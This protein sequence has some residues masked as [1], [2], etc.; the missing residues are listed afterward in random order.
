MNEISDKRE[1]FG[2]GPY[3]VEARHQRLGQLLEG[4]K[5]FFDKDGPSEKGRGLFLGL[6]KDFIEKERG[7][8]LARHRS[9]ASGREIVAEHTEL[10][11]V[12]VRHLY[13]LA[14]E[15]GALG[16]DLGGFAL[17]A[18]GGYGRG[19]L[20][21][22]S[23]VDL[24]FLH[25]RWPEGRLG[26]LLRGILYPLWDVG[27]SVGHCCRC[28]ED[29]LQ[30]AEKD[31]ISRT[32]M[33]EAR[34]LVG[35]LALYQRFRRKLER[36]VRGR[37]AE[38]YVENKIAEREARY[39]KYGASL[40]LQEPNVKE[41]AG[42]LRDLHTAFWIARARHGVATF[43]DMVEKG[44]LLP[45]E[46]EDGERCLEFL[47]RLRNELHYLMGDKN[48]VLSL[49]LQRQVAENLGFHDMERAYG[50]ELFMQQYYLNARAVHR[51]SRT[52]VDRCAAKRSRMEAVMKK[53]RARDLGDGLTE[54]N[55]QI[56]IL[57]KDAGL[58]QEDPVRLMKIFWYA[59]QTGYGLS[60]EAQALARTHL[61]LIDDGFRSSNR[62]FGFFLAILREPV[63]VAHTLRT[64]HELGVLGAYIPEFA[65]LNCLVQF[66]FY[67]KYTVDEHTFIGLENLEK[68]LQVP[69]KPA[70]EFSVIAHELKRP[71]IL[72]LAVL[73]HDIGKGEGKEHVEK[74]V[75]MVPT[76]LGRWGLSEAEVE[77]VR[78][79]VAHHLTMAHIAERRDLDDERMVI[80]FV[81]K[82]QRVDLLKML[83]L[84]TYLDIKAVGPEAW[85]EWKGAL[86]WE[87][88]LKSHTIL[89]RGVPEGEEEL[90]KAAKIRSQ[91]L[92]ELSPEFSGGEVM[93]HL[94]MM[95]IRYQLT[96]SGAKVASHLRLARL[97]QGGEPLALV[98]T[99]F[100]LVG[101]SEVTVCAPGVP[102]RFAK[103]AGTFTANS[104][105][106][107]SA[108]IFTRRDGL[109]FRTFQVNDGRGS[110]ILDEGV[111]LRLSRDLGA[112]LEGRVEVEEL[113]KAR[114]P[115]LPSRE[116][117]WVPPRPSRVEFDNYVSETHTV[118]DVRT[119][120]R[121]GLLYS[122]S[123]A[124]STLGLDLSLAKITTEVDQAVDVFYVTERDGS[125][126]QEGER[127]EEIRTA[128]ERAVAQGL[129]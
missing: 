92:K 74:S 127:M 40:Y 53:L 6:F 108:Q 45:E 4:M 29:C 17:L 121:L 84:L 36:K 110:A 30:I 63:G 114:R 38:I 18:L 88:Y 1:P 116:M 3:S 124:L 12:V 125:K 26:S 49:S 42:G 46:R 93:G 118:I 50:V 51:L 86:L 7:E 59:Q 11:D 31:L 87:L 98:W 33:L 34:F 109:V 100:P 56:H 77:E 75:R 106:I 99:N 73:I 72:R 16:E 91:L 89:T 65:K 82:V 61:G 23:D 68:L 21:P 48:D 62:A 97:V 44:L 47:F 14:V 76:I 58:F 27:F 94:E 32:S 113:L 70:E 128:L 10:V 71:E 102:G 112:V 111:W 79:L 126:V 5:P 52:L 9:R 78:F 104:I 67:H 117:K 43:Q 105:N 60:P 95:P 54:I 64:M 37:Q 28:P 24:M 90:V 41:S 115:R 55:R 81:K 20:N 83:Y 19:E 107:L 15:G 96:T 122:I 85:S 35:D 101:Y 8:I 103:I 119:P 66:D 129:D 69:P 39:R 13:R 57:P 123:S 22:A 25:D 2:M 80:E 120:D